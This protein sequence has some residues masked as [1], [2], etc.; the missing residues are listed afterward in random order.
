MG[1]FARIVA[2]VTRNG[3][4]GHAVVCVYPAL[5]RADHHSEPWRLGV[6]LMAHHAVQ[7][8]GLAQCVHAEA[9]VTR[10]PTGGVLRISRR[11]HI[12]LEAFSHSRL[13]RS[14]IR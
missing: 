11:D 6:A 1:A 8:L 10:G 2:A 4:R 5:A 7:W 3:R 9:R 13:F 12:A 14:R